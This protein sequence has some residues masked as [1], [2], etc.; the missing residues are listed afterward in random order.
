MR[1]GVARALSFVAG[2]ALSAGSARAADSRVEQDLQ[3]AE[4]ALVSLDYE[5]ANKAAASLAE[6]HGLSHAE[7]V[8]A[9]RVLALTDAILDK[10]VAAR[11][12]FQRLLTYDPSYAADPNLGPKVQTPFLEARGFMRAQ[13]TQPGLDVSVSVRD[14]VGGAVRVIARD[15]SHSA[16]RAVVGFRW[17]SDVAFSTE[18]IALV[19]G[20]SA[21]VP[22]PPPGTTRLDYYVQVFDERDDAVLESG[23]PSAPKSVTV[24][25]TPVAPAPA[26]VPSAHRSIFESP[27]FWTI[28]GIVVVGAGTGAYFAG[29]GGSSAASPTAVSLSLSAQCGY[30]ASST[31][32]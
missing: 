30:P 19:E 32:R 18:P 23:N 17:G 11:E 20:A 27:V 16:K 10:E 8:R 29:R 6:E 2:V 21:P 5:A 4:Q 13:T 25:L 1:L 14:G 3:A 15:P 9:Y 22:P 26:P 12:A 7:L 24:E 31:C 28:A